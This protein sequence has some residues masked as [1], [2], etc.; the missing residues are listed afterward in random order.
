LGGRE[1][2]VT[3]RMK[4][5]S[6]VASTHTAGVLATGC[7]KRK[8][9]RART[10]GSIKHVDLHGV[11]LPFLFHPLTSHT[12]CLQ[13]RHHSIICVT[14]SHNHL[15]PQFRLSMLNPLIPSLMYKVFSSH[16]LPQFPVRSS[17]IIHAIHLPRLAQ[18]KET[19]RE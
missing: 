1:E 3:R 2:D 5:C 8:E 17:I 19:S 9:N 11:S 12:L 6:Y 7:I 13:S 14:I 4:M 16:P 10:D 15:A 18:T